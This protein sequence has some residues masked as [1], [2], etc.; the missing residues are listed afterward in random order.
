MILSTLCIVEFVAADDDVT[1]GLMM[2]TEARG[3]PP[4][5]IID[6]IVVMEEGIVHFE[7]CTSSSTLFVK[8]MDF[9]SMPSWGYDDDDEMP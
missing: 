3:G 2:E 4:A 1:L 8:L 6:E 9:I 7:S 5:G